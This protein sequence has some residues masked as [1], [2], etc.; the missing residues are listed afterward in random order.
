MRGGGSVVTGGRR[1]RRLRRRHTA[2]EER[3]DAT[4]GRRA[5]DGNVNTRG[6]GG[7]GRP[8]QRS[9][10]LPTRGHGGG[11]R[12]RRR[13]QRRWRW[14]LRSPPAAGGDAAAEA[15]A[16]ADVGSCRWSRRR[17]DCCRGRRGRCG[18]GGCRGSAAGDAGSVVRRHSAKAER[19]GRGSGVGGGRWRIQRGRRDGV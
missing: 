3:K 12:R 11:R 18:G 10:S 9:Q 8:G 13:R 15:A 5:S 16:P 4:G 17:H 2:T 6:H 19:R 1:R 7:E 14:R